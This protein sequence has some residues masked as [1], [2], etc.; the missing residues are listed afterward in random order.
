MANT[1]IPD[2]PLRILCRVPMQG[3]YRWMTYHE[4]VTRITAAWFDCP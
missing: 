3:Q 1:S 2:K 4:S